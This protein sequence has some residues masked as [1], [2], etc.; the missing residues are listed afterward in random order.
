MKKD[1]IKVPDTS[2]ITKEYIGKWV[3]LSDD[4]LRVIASGETLAEVLRKTANEKRK[5]VFQVLPKLGYAPTT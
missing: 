3:A 5:A 1:T 2:E 4:Y